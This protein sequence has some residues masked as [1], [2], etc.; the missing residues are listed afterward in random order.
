MQSIAWQLSEAESDG[1]ASFKPCS[2]GALPVSQVLR[3][4]CVLAVAIKSHRG[5][6]VAE[7]AAHLHLCS[8]IY[9]MAA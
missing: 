5:I 2:P 7:S 6:Q 4:L 3:Q 1:L 8:L 9:I